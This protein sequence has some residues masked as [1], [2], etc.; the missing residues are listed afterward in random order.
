MNEKVNELWSKLGGA[1]A[2]GLGLMPWIVWGLGRGR[3]SSDPI[4]EVLDRLRRHNEKL[5][6][7]RDL[8]EY[9]FARAGR[10]LASFADATGEQREG[11][12]RAALLY[13]ACATGALHSASD[14]EA[15][16]SEAED[17]WLAEHGAEQPASNRTWVFARS[18]LTEAHADEELRA[19]LLAVFAE[20]EQKLRPTADARLRTAEPAS[21]WKTE[22]VAEGGWHVDFKQGRLFGDLSEAER[23]AILHSRESW[24][25][26]D[27][28]AAKWSYQPPPAP[29][30]PADGSGLSPGGGV[31]EVDGPR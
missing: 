22:E 31:D 2:L 18:H 8:A 30:A 24:R 16:A 23:A 3:R 12:M 11:I 26:G 7:S 13:A 20:V 29:P 9:G 14:R 28:I 21:I 5:T 25:V 1:A 17:Q 27:I 4:E 6:H 10:I 15:A 19:K